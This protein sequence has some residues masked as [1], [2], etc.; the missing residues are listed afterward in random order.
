ME[1]TAAVKG[2]QALTEA[3]EV[4]VVTDSTYLKKGITSWIRG[5]KRNGW[6]TKEGKPVLNRDLWEALDAQAERHKLTWT[7]TRGHDSHEDNN[8]VDGLASEAAVAQT[9]GSR[10]VQKTSGS[11]AS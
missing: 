2:L 7:W 8:Y 9:G 10:V 3:C 1:L 11:E 5:W 6:Q 4:E